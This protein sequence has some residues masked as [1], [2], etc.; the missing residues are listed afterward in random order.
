MR[1][2]PRQHYILWSVQKSFQWSTYVHGN[3]WTLVR[4]LSFQSVHSTVSC[5]VTFSPFGWLKL[6]CNLREPRFGLIPFC[7]ARL[8]CV[9]SCL[10]LA[11]DNLKRRAY[12]THILNH[13]IS[14]THA[15]EIHVYAPF[16]FLNLKCHFSPLLTELFLPQRSCNSFRKS[17]YSIPLYNSTGTFFQQG[18]HWHRPI[19]YCHSG[20][21]TYCM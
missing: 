1:V 13:T 14:L 11:A 4:T 21:N 17:F 20:W 10:I 6:W 18:D 8:L 3:V 12:C 15:A 9:N 2:V 19:S 16:I 7:G 5:A